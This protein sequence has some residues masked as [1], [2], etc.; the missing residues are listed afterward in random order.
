MDLLKLLFGNPLACVCLVLA[1]GV[2]AVAYFIYTGSTLNWT[3]KK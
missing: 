3:K 1:G 2:A